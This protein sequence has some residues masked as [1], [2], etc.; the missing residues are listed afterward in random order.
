MRH[1]YGKVQMTKPIIGGVGALIQ[2]VYH[3]G[4][5]CLTSAPMGHR[6]HQAVGYETDI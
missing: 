1:K 6:N 4:K 3:D 2:T 5:D